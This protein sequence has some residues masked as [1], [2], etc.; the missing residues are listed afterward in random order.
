MSFVYKNVRYK[1]T[2]LISACNLKKKK[3]HTITASCLKSLQARPRLSQAYADI[4]H[5]WFRTSWWLPPHWLMLWCYSM[6][7]Y[8]INAKR[9]LLTRPTTYSNKN[10]TITAHIQVPASGI[11]PQTP[12]TAANP[13]PPRRCLPRYRP[14]LPPPTCPLRRRTPPEVLLSARAWRPSFDLSVEVCRL[15][16]R[17]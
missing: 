10:T 13:T 7:S 2:M 14:L 16:F 8:T 1:Q 6:T 15:P 5:S 11:P 3:L 4:N 17:K 9:R 12:Q